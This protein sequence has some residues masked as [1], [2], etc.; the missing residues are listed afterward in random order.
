ME[1]QYAD[2]KGNKGLY[3]HVESSHYMY[4]AFS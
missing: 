4:G 1:E 3:Q 2:T